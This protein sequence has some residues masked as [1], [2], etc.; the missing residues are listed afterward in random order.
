MAPRRVIT[1]AIER[2]VG[3]TVALG[4]AH[5]LPH[6]AALLDRLPDVPK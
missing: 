3:F 2:I 1:D 6:A 5:E 4:R